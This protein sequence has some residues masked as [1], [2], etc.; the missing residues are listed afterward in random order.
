MFSLTVSFHFQFQSVVGELTQCAMVDFSYTYLVRHIVPGPQSFSYFVPHILTPLSLFIPRTVLSRRQS[1]AI[2]LPIILLS[3][4]HAWVV[5][6]GVDVISVNAV[7]IALL[8]LPL[9]D[10]HTQFKLI[11]R[12]GR[13]RTSAQHSSAGDSLQE[14]TALLSPSDD[15]PPPSTPSKPSA[16]RTQAY[17]PTLRE[18]LPWVNMLLI[19]IRFNDWLIAIS[20]HDRTQPQPPAFQTRRQF[21]LQALLSSVRGLLTIDLTHAYMTTDAYFTD[22]NISLYSPLPFASVSGIAAMGIRSTVLGA[23]IW[24]ALSQL[25]YLFATLPVGLNALGL[26]DDLWSPHTWGAYYGPASAIFTHGLRGFWGKYWHQTMRITTSAPGYALA[27]VLGQKGREWKRYA[28]ISLVAFGCSGVVHMGLVPAEPLWATVSPNRLRLYMGLFF[29]VQPVGMLGEMFEE[30]LWTMSTGREVWE[31]G[32]MYKVRL[33]GTGM[34]VLLW[35]MACLPLIGE[36]GRQLGWFKFSILPVSLWQ[37]LRREGWIT[38][39]ILQK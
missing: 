38:W 27:D 16:Y 14:E 25:F 11:V 31:R 8:F 35:F 34:S 22:P 7:L 12:N 37:G 6:D 33:V 28:V 13:E 2:F 21:F 9:K 32:R 23:Q 36:V 5:M 4:L 29:W 24:A 39:P 20:S 3:T 17:P 1:I 10:P 18:R 30:S 19:S 15:A 26:L